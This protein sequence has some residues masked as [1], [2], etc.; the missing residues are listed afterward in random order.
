MNA[1][2]K[3]AV[4]RFDDN[5]IEVI[6]TAWITNDDTAA[7]W[8][9]FKT[10]PQFAKFVSNATEPDKK[11]WELVSVQVK[12]IASKHFYKLRIICIILLLIGAYEIFC[13][14]L[15]CYV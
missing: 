13:H 5:S 1:A 6:P 15:H 3:F 10:V 4:V 12:K 14:C 2:K 11:K 9:P 7:Y 8:P